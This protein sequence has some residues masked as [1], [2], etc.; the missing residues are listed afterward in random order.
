MPTR[1]QFGTDGWR[2][3]IAESFT[4][5]NVR[6]AA[7]ASAEYFISA[8]QAERGIVVGYDTRFGSARF[9]AAAAEVDRLDGLTVRL[10]GKR[11]F[12]LRP[13][14][15]EP[16]LRLNVEAPDRP[17]MA[18]LRDEVLAMVRA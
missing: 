7:Q 4:F 3:T 10:P 5:D 6:I 11:W 12:N 17:A 2:A 1:I 18:A 14:N 13:S 15:T 9:A 8:H 16:L